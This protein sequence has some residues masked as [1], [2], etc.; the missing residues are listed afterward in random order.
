MEINQK[1]INQPMLLL[2]EMENRL[3]STAKEAVSTLQRDLFEAVL[4]NFPLA[5]WE[6]RPVSDLY[7]AMLGF[8]SFLKSRA[9]AE[10]LVS[11]SNPSLE[12]DGWV[13]RRTV[14]K[15]CCTDSPF[16]VDTVRMVL[17]DGEYAIHVSKSTVL[18]VSRDEQGAL[19][20]LSLH[21][22]T[23]PQERAET[24]AYFEITSISNEK[25][26][27]QLSE[28]ILKALE[29]VDVVVRD[30][31]PMLA[32]L[33]VAADSLAESG[34]N[35]EIVEFLSW[36]KQSNFTFLGYR[37]F[38]FDIAQNSGELDN[39]ATLNEIVDSRLGTFNAVEFQPLKL[40]ASDFPEGAKAFYQSE[41]KICFSKSG[42]RSSVHRNVY[43]DYVVLKTY[44]ENGLVSGE[45]RFLGFFTYAVSSMSPS[46]IPILRGKVKVILNAFGLNPRS[47]DGKRLIRFIDLHPKEEFFQ[48]TADELSQT[49]RKI[50]GLNE[51]DIIRFIPRLDPFGQFVSCLLYVPKDLYT[52][53]LRIKIQ[54]L[55]GQEIGAQSADVNTFFSESKHARAHMVFR[56]SSD[57]SYSGDLTQLESDIRELANG[58][59]EHFRKA[60]DEHFGES[61]GNTKFKHYCSAF[62]QSYQEQFDARSAV[63]DI[64]TFESLSDNKSIAMHLYQP[65]GCAGNELRF[66]VVHRESMLELSAVIPILEN[67]GLRVLGEQPFKVV[68]RDKRIFWLHDFHLRTAYSDD[69]DVKRVSKHFE[70]AFAVIWNRGVSSDN[71]NSLIL[72]AGLP[73]QQ[74]NLLRAYANYMKQTLFQISMEYIAETLCLY[75]D[76]SSNLAELFTIRF[77]PSSHDDL[78]LRSQKADELTARILAALDDIAVLNQDKVIRRYVDLIN[79]TLRTNFFQDSKKQQTTPYISLK[80][81]P[82]AIKEIPE[83][84]PAF[85][86]FVY[87]SRVEGVHLRTSKVARGGLRWS[88]RLEDYRTEVLGLVKAQQVKNAVIVPSGAKGGFVAKQIPFN[89]SR[90]EFIAE[91]IECYKIFIQGLLD[92]TDN[93]NGDEVVKPLKVVCHDGDDPYLVVAADKGTATFSDIANEISLA[94]GHWLGDAFAS[95][96]SQGYDHK[97]MGIT[98]KGAWVSVQRHFRELGVNTQTDEF[99]VVGIGDM[100]GDVFGN[101]MLLSKTIKLVAA[102]N[103]M[104]IFIDPNPDPSK[105]YDE[106]LR[107]FNTP[108]CSWA[109]YDKALISEG[110]GVFN[111]SDKFISLSAQLQALIDCKKS[112]LTPTELMH[113][114]LKSK[115]DLIWNGGIGTYVKSSKEQHSDVGDKANDALRVNGAEL[116]C[117]VFGE[118]GNLGMTQ[119]GRVEFALS[120]GACNTDFIDN[121][122][123]VDCSDHEVNIKILIDAQCKAGDLTPKQ[124]NQLLVDMTD[125]VAELVLDNNYN[126]TLALSVA[127]EQVSARMNE[128]RRFMSYLVEQGRLDRGLEFLPEDTD[129]VD[130]IGKG[131]ALSRPELS[132]LISYAK[133]QLKE[134]LSKSNIAGDS[135]CAKSLLTVFPQRLCDQYSEQINAHKLRK[136]IIATQLANDFINNL[137][138]TSLHRLSETTG[139]S[140]E[141]I[142]KAY[143]VARDIF[144]LH[145]FAD[146]VSSLDY[147]INASDQYK[148]LAS[149]ARRV[150]RGT[151]WLLKNR[152]AGF[153]VEAEINSFKAPLANVQ[154]AVGELL[155]EM[156]L[157][158][159]KARVDY[160]AG[161]NV[162]AEWIDVLAMPDNLFSGMGV[163]EVSIKSGASVEVCAEVFMSLL[164][165]LKLDW[166]A[167]QLSD[168]KV[169][170]Y[171]QASAREA[172]IDDLEAQLRKLSAHIV[173]CAEKQSDSAEWVAAWM[174]ANRVMISRWTSMVNKVESSSKTDYAMFAVALK[175][176]HDL[177]QITVHS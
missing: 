135:Y 93:L 22:D 109:D 158:K 66:R 133:V 108:G 71:F 79:A 132:V 81:N 12:T 7:S 171:W 122:A 27:E 60:L 41:E 83:P 37:E 70:E 97:G 114:L 140:Y 38:K 75:P 45:L 6:G 21:D 19:E 87:S 29:H 23:K 53:T 103:H 147:A 74:V 177:V 59:L 96:G 156:D 174:Q 141:E 52:T 10:K 3:K 95:G 76:L 25:E 67:M 55:I 35:G 39:N 17:E 165:E 126:Q 44:N 92:L 152:R 57:G 5:D 2:K 40:K 24:F 8:Y 131:Q 154:R 89:A 28:K 16:L 116:R 130:R 175:E 145:G 34:D 1:Y 128:Y 136:E 106:R 36:L 137:G 151:R 104:H 172:Y 98:A 4:A 163:V 118:G 49:F 121:A 13:C 161:L 54:N 62:S 47:H 155:S 102:F 31:R 134:E 111:R 26:R 20:A 164:H 127:A 63:D 72:V 105:S 50:I 139:A 18:N 14:V 166:F 168:M 169:E 73:W 88:D 56:L 51:R 43:P 123:G 78:G 110:G 119:L 48:A 115:V 32:R 159:R 86:F 94:K 77:S 143:V 120:G 15:F 144:K 101:G 112:R 138:I 91:G 61:K 113:Y 149:M 170:S 107:L 42:T 124:R 65:V 9:K 157:E 148:L 82:R 167:T 160:L 33:E 99:S 11:V 117:R 146:F 68:R 125:D 30:Y 90:A 84:R 176:L 69:V 150:R 80:I 142:V 64:V 100:A 162:S 58:W 173:I 153:D 85:E 46:E 129:V